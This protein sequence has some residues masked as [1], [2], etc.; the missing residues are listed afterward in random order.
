ME[1]VLEKNNIFKS[2]LVFLSVLL[3]VGVILPSGQVFAEESNTLEMEVKSENYLDTLVQENEDL[4]KEISELS[5]QGLQV[6]P[7]VIN[8]EGADVITYSNED[9]TI[10]GMIQVR[11]KKYTIIQIDLNNDNTFKD[12]FLQDENG[13]RAYVNDLEEEVSQTENINGGISTMASSPSPS[14]KSKAC[15]I[16]VGMAGS[17]VT[18]VY[19]AVATAVGTPVAGFFVGLLSAGGWGLVSSYC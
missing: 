13:E 7:D 14:A 18:S 6:D 19:V 10:S 1:S 9:Q 16:L 17:G 2:I 11:D 8:V 12:G 3:L 15:S 5:A 4:N